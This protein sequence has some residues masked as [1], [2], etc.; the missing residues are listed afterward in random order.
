MPYHLP[1][2]MTP[3]SSYRA[4]VCRL[5]DSFLSQPRVVATPVRSVSS[6]L[7]ESRPAVALPLLYSIT[8][9]AA[10]E[11][12]IIAAFCWI[13]SNA[14]RSNC[15]VTPGCSV[16]KISTALSQAMPMAPFALS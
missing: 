4:V 14:L 7:E 12:R 10:S 1:D 16:L 3:R 8:S 6:P 13:C 5:V 11:L 9:G 2:P 15:T